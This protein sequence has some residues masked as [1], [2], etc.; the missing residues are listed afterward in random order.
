MSYLDDLE[1]LERNPSPF[2]SGVLRK[3]KETEPIKRDKLAWCRDYDPESA[4][5]SIGK[6]TQ[7]PDVSGVF[8]EVDP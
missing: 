3:P 8:F 4:E 1:E 7:D 6:V 5:S 2:Y